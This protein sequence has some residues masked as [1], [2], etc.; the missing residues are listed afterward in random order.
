MTEA[1]LLRASKLVTASSDDKVSYWSASNLR[2]PAEMLK[3]N[4]N[5]SCLETLAAPGL[6]STEVHWEPRQ[7]RKAI[8]QQSST[9]MTIRKYNVGV[10]KYAVIWHWPMVHLFLI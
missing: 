5:L 6:A 4:A 9:A 3:V 7:S 10:N 1:A 2:E 8:T